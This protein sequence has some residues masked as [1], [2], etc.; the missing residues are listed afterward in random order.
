MEL[1]DSEDDGGTSGVTERTRNDPGTD[2]SGVGTDA[3][4][5]E[6]SPVEYV[7]SVAALLEEDPKASG[8][9]IGN[10]LTIAREDEGATRVAAGEAL[11]AIGRRYP[12]SLAVW[13][14]YLAE[15]AAD[16][17]DEVAFFAMR[18]V[19]QLAAVNPQAA[20]KAREAALGNVGAPSPD[21]RQAALSVVAEVG[22]IE[23]DAVQRADRP[24]SAAF[25]DGH[26]GVRTAA[27]IAAGRLLA[28]APSRFPRT[29]NGLV[30]AVD[31]DDDRVRTYALLALANFASEHP[32]NVPRKERAIAALA[33]ADDDDLGLRRGAMG[34]A[35]AALVSL[36]FE[37]EAATS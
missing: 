9:A 8:D 29:A 21:L 30:D 36:T 22:P 33:N 2:R 10:L 1:R 32:S 7:E 4:A 14:D 6:L 27:A 16:A 34:E 15:A 12:G 19:A 26:A 18:A 13:S 11:D 20:A 37:D 5:S 28:A 31:D 23:P 35:L 25:D 17:D 24:L 3:G